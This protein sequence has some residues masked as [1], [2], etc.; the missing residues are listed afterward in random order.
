MAQVAIGAL[1]RESKELGTLDP[2]N[3]HTLGGFLNLEKDNATN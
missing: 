1:P 2:D 3:N